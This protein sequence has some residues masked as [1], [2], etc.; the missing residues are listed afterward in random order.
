M[1]S[2]SIVTRLYNSCGKSLIWK[3]SDGFCPTMFTFRLISWYLMTLSK[4]YYNVVTLYI[5][6][7]CYFHHFCTKLLIPC[8]SLIHI[9]H[10]LYRFC[11]C[12]S[13]QQ[14]NERLSNDIE[15][16]QERL[17]SADQHTQTRSPRGHRGQRSAISITFC[18]FL[19]S[20]V[21][22]RFYRLDISTC[23]SKKICE[24]F[25]CENYNLNLSLN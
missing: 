20:G 16:L 5:L 1:L 10:I 4:L 19:N 8:N 6:Q 3:R 7:Q 11:K 24:V 13:F 21:D 15:R 17:K 14:R 23:T 22:S 25:I 9:H 18:Q 12:W 2:L